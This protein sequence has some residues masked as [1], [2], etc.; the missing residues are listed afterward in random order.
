ML[1][2]H[3]MAANVF[4]SFY[5]FGYLTTSMLKTRSIS[6]RGTPESPSNRVSLEAWDCFSIWDRYNGADMLDFDFSSV[7]LVLVQ[8]SIFINRIENVTRTL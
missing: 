4:H 2:H 8:V 5:G 1:H 3:F 7:C 6:F